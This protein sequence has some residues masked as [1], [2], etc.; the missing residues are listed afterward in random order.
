[1]PGLNLG[2]RQ[3]TRRS[4]PDEQNELYPNQ[5]LH[6]LQLRVQSVLSLISATRGV[7][8]VHSTDSVSKPQ[9]PSQQAPMARE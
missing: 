9:L 8:K 2:P 7:P 1:M 5:H 6:S 3:L 4:S